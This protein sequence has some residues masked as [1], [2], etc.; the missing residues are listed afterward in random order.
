M[1]FLKI[2]W[3]LMDFDVVRRIEKKL[4]LFVFPHVV[5]D[6]VVFSTHARHRDSKNKGALR[7]QQSHLIGLVLDGWT[8]QVSA[9]RLNESSAKPNVCFLCR[10]A[11]VL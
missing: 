3:I 1:I 11:A 7:K 5:V 9:Q 2:R 8:L 4:M 10:N 6:K